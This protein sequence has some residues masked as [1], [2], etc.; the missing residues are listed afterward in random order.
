MFLLPS[1]LLGI[2]FALLLGGKPSRVLR[3]E[4]RHGWAVFVSLG[5]QVVLFSGLRESIPETLLEPLHLLTYILLFW[6][7]LAN[8][9]TLVL[10]PLFLGMALNAI[11]IVAN[12]GRMP[13]NPEA[14]AATGLGDSAHSNVA[15]GADRLA[16]LGDIFALPNE[17]P[18]TNVFSIGDLLLGIGTIIL[19]VMVS[20]TESSRRTLSPG[21]LLE[22]LRVPSF[23]HLA[24]G[25]LVSQL[26]DW[27]TVAALVGWIWEETGSVSQVAV[28]PGQAVNAGD[29]LV[30]VTPATG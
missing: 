16:F 28:T 3:L 6:F 22:P 25:K 13:V 15:V 8:F 19:I 29:L 17:L 23:R 30:V 14:W 26:G 21:R 20:T 27:I 7:A 24:G 12:G 18:L 4:V 11:A 9:R 10:L 2:A 1:I 5:L